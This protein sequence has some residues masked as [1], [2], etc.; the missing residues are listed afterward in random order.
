MFKF[1]PYKRIPGPLA[2]AGPQAWP[3]QDIYLSFQAY[4]GVWN[5]TLSQALQGKLWCD[6]ILSAPA[7]LA[8]PSSASM[9]ILEYMEQYH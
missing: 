1:V 5:R 2:V 9:P 7:V 3:T 8:E 6:E 4:Q